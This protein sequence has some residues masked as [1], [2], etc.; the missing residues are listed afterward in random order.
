MDAENQFYK[1]YLDPDRL[2]LF[3]RSGTSF[4][5]HVFTVK[6]RIVTGCSSYVREL[7]FKGMSI[8][9][10]ASKCAFSKCSLKELDITPG[11]ADWENMLLRVRNYLDG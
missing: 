2:R 7:V 11:S 5:S 4:R 9:S 10:V 1:D 8:D 3:I 6:N